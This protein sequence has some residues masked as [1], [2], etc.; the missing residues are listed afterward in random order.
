MPQPGRGRRFALPPMPRRISLRAGERRYPARFEWE[1]RL[2]EVVRPGA[3]S[4]EEDTMRNTGRL[5]V[6]HHYD[7]D[8]V[9]D[10]YILY[11]LKAFRDFGARLLFVSNSAL[12]EAEVAK[13]GEFADS[14]TLRPNRGYDFAGWKQV[15]LEHGR[16]FCAQF[17]EVV[18]VNS[19]FYGPLFDLSEMFEE[20][21]RRDCDF[22][23][24][25]QHGAAHG[26][27][28]HVQPYFLVV[29]R[30]LHQSDAF[31]NF[32]QSVREDFD[33]LWD[34]VWNAEIRLTQDWCAAGFRCSTYV[35]LPDKTEMRPIGYYEPYAMHA[36]DR[37]IAA[38]RLPFVKVKAFYKYEKRPF[39]LTRHIFAAL[40][41]AES[42]YPRDLIVRHQRR[43]SPLS[44]HKN[45]PGT[46]LVLPDGA[47]DAVP[48][49]KGSGRIGVF[50]HFFY[51]DM[52]DVAVRYLRN[53]PYE[54]DMFLTTGSEGAAAA[55]RD[56][57]AGADLRL[58]R[59]EVKAVQNR[60]RDIAP[61]LIEFRDEHL[62]YEIAL[63]IH[64]KK[65]SHHPEAFGAKWNRYMYECLLTSPRYV[66]EIVRAFDEQPDLGIAFPPYAPLYNMVFPEGYYGSLEDQA[67][68]QGVL[69]ALGI[70]PPA[71]TCQ[72][73]FSAGG[74]S[75]YRP[76]ALRRLLEWR[77]GYDD[78]PAEPHPTS[79][80]ISHGLE[81]VI[82]YVAQADGFSY[83]LLMPLSELETGYQMYE[84][85]IMSVFD[86]V[87]RE[88]PEGHPNVPASL[89]SLIVAVRHAYHRKFPGFGKRMAGIEERIYGV[90][91]KHLK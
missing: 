53:I 11:A 30:A 25:T 47:E 51:P 23:T 7:R 8:A 20:M 76:R 74:M 68:R 40:D 34:A 73:I 29:R 42:G 38:F 65:H 61:W 54:F 46:L 60:G 22:W 79:G 62:G 36:V 17:D 75:W 2:I 14:V 21:A 24:P 78:F 56:A 72:P 84:D 27:P 66:A 3:G 18:L 13:V 59:L 33:D 35:D 89:L 87:Y 45:L 16:D 70:A 41:E 9:V 86:R 10:D 28:F 32:W 44:W 5:F 77:I 50:G 64:L 82:P 85:R 83:R 15:L 1:Q 6:F 49:R 19:S 4:E 52:L 80:T 26:I 67:H 12:P 69:D 48:V 71:E 88:T 90:L 91:K 31:W 43:V 37:M 81:R 39:T 63:K 55:I 57:A 58:G